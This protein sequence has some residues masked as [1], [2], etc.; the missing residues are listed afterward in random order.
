LFSFACLCPPGVLHSQLGMIIARICPIVT[1]HIDL[2]SVTSTSRLTEMWIRRTAR[3][4][5]GTLV[6][7]ANPNDLH[8]LHHQ[9]RNTAIT[10][11]DV[12]SSPTFCSTGQLRFGGSPQFSLGIALNHWPWRYDI[13]AQAT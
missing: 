6:A 7:S 11:T 5:V 9:N 10:A 1:H 12:L 2:S 8:V 3:R 4:A 13:V